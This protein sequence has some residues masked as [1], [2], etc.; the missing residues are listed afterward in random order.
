MSEIKRVTA[1]EKITADASGCRWDFTVDTRM[2]DENRVLRPD[3]V[4]GLNQQSGEYLFRCVGLDNAILEQQGVAVVYT[5][6]WEHFERPV[7]LDENV[8]L[9]TFMTLR[10]G[11]LMKR[12]ANLSVNGEQVASVCTE[13]V[14]ID[15]STRSMLTKEKSGVFSCVPCPNTDNIKLTRFRTPENIE[16]VGTFDIRYADIDFN[17][18]MNNT[19][20][21][22]VLLGF[23]PGGM[24]GKWLC[25][26]L[27]EYHAEC[28][29][30]DTLTV[31]RG[32]DGDSFVF[33]LLGDDGTEHFR[34]KL[35]VGGM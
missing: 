23:I 3:W 1:E 15:T 26:A 17:G 32:T 19:K 30:G 12:T 5:R 8:E 4:L 20:Y 28:R 18:H 25:D 34:A 35:I 13:A 7:M 21:I 11:S 31:M 22:N 29:A 33:S 27:M 9:D 24:K 6:I 14:A 16:K 2:M 10:R